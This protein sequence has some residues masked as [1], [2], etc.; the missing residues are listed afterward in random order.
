MTLLAA[1]KTL[2]YRYT[3]QEDILIGSPVAGRYQAETEGLI[4]FFV[5]NLAL[6]TDL[7]GAPT[8]RQVL[9]RVRKVTLEAYDN[10]HVPFDK[11]VEVLQPERDLSRLPF[12]QVL[13]TLHNTAI[14]ELELQGVRMQRYKF[15]TNTT[16]YDLTL[17]IW[18][19]PE[20]LL[21]DTEFCTD[22]FEVDTIRRM[23]GHY[24]T[25]LRG[26]VAD[27]DCKISELSLLTVGER[28]RLLFEWNA[29]QAD[30]PRAQ[31][32]HRLF[33]RQ[34]AGSP[35]AI[36]VACA[37]DNILYGELNARA[38]QLAHHM[39][40]LGVETGTLVGIYME[41]SI[42]MIVALLAVHKSG[43]AYLPLDPAFPSD[44]LAFMVE[45]SQTRYLISQQ[46]L[47][48][49]L[50]AHQAQVVYIDR[51]WPQIVVQPASNLEDAVTYDGER[52]AYVL[53]TS[54]STG[55]PKGV[56]V[57]QRALVNFLVAM[58][59]SPGL[60]RE[61]ILLSVTTLSFDIA[62]LEIFLP[63][64]TGAQIEM[65][66][67][68]VAA[69]GAALLAVLQGCG[70]T[71]MQATPATWRLLIS[72]GWEGTPGLKI[73]C[74]GEAMPGEL[75]GQLLPRCASLWNMYGP[76]ETT[77]WS[78]V[79]QVG[80]A[81]GIMPIGRAI[82]NTQVYILDEARQP[83][84]LGVAGELYIGG[85]GVAH[86]YLNRPEL[87]A[88]KFVHDPFV[89]EVGAR[90]YRTGDLVRY[91][92]DGNLDFLGR[93]DFQVKIRGFRIELGEIEALLDEHPS[94]H[95]AVVIAREDTPGDLRLVAY[96]AVART[97]APA[98]SELRSY[99]KEKL[100]DYMVP[101]VFVTVETFP[102]TPNGKVNRKAL[103]APSV[104]R[105][106]TSV[107]HVAPRNDI[108]RK[109]AAMWQSVL[110]VE[111]VGVTDNFFDL[112][113]HSLLIVQVHNQIRRSFD[114]NVTIAQMF[115]YPTVEALAAH[116]QRP[117]IAAGNLQQAQER[118]L[119][120]RAQ[121]EQPIRGRR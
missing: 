28:N 101:S 120:Q 48:D 41:R 51:D 86:G 100:P 78:T 64:I 79:C 70:A 80:K 103:P 105:V 2:L 71:V 91:R 69:D 75:A 1:F 66:S 99:L 18:E 10:Q 88:E 60:A 33:E 4:G 11:L 73:L 59:Q 31:P 3:R 15:E 55:R 37:G 30:Y 21:I 49:Q 17:E 90:M 63:L 47:Q 82:A 111:K 26:I 76:T 42:E 95:Q 117:Q 40:S 77:I 45:D 114:T 74:G 96:L 57:P 110:G 5:N 98:A 62:G 81:E 67:H 24:A 108:E 115:Q 106:E 72:A 112:G 83:T 39:R 16:R 116:L 119:R 84:P 121:F 107:N 97:E 53:Y 92:A 14:E 50:P 8:F 27:P 93:V 35:T 89:G 113:G 94:V 61:D 56:Q 68:V 22:L 7:S 20:G 29:T 104:A 13:F 102:L 85:D 52:L 43:G 44:R 118:A 87:T 23:Q 9:Q 46:R 34:A 65:V 38:N 19:R 12:F 25:L 32:V 54:G 6:R 36:A 109:I 58:Q